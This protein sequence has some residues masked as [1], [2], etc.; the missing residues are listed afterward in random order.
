MKRFTILFIT[1]LLLANSEV[2]NAQD[3]AFSQFYANPLYLNPALAGSATCPRVVLNYRN[4]WPNIRATYVTYAASFDQYVDGIKGGVGLQAYH[5]RA[6]DGIINTNS[7]SGMYAYQLNVDRNLSIKA[8][9]QATYYSRAIDWSELTFGDQIHERYGF[10]YQTQ[11]TPINS[12]VNEVD[13]STGFLAFTKTFYAGLAV[14]HLT[15]PNE[16]FFVGQESR[17]YRRY[18]GHMGALIPLNK[19]IPE[20]GSISPNIIYQY[21]GNSQELNL[22]MYL[23]KGPITGGVWYRWGD[24]L[25]FLVGIYT[26]A[27]RF[28]YSYDITVS[29]LGTKTAGSH[30]LSVTLMFP[31]KPKTRKLRQIQCPQF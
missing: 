26:D 6:G 8:G 24:A 2:A 16:S 17:L 29:R 12:A 7:F 14:H 19:Q 31:C 11:E 9:F 30:E 15:Q 13:F 5:D 20:E 22:G 10:I 21:Q 28:G 27:F 18:T 3:P 1:A 25:I 23:N 4:Q